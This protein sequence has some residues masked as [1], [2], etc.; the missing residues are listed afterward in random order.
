M[1]DIYKNFRKEVWNYIN[2]ILNLINPL[3][4][5][6]YFIRG[7]HVIS[8]IFTGIFFYLFFTDEVLWKKL[9]FF[10]VIFLLGITY[11]TNDK[12]MPFWKQ[13]VQ[14]ICTLGFACL[15]GYAMYLLA[16]M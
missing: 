5:N 16:K 1:K 3:L 2:R 9:N 12:D 15:L 4:N 8:W 7:V 13:L 6:K 11:K 10:E 14:I